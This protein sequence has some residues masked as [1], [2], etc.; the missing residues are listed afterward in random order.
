[1]HLSI[2]RGEFVDRMYTDLAVIDV[3]P[4]GSVV[5]EIVEGRAYDELQRM[6][7]VPLCFE[8]QSS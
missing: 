8:P 6:A 1:V 5:R 3:T 2:D 4:N 7:G